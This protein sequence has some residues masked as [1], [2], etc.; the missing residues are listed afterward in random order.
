MDEIYWGKTLRAYLIAAGG[1]LVAL[2]VLRV[3]RTVV[4]TRLKKLADKTSFR[5]DD[6]IISTIQRFVVPF[7]YFMVAFQVVLSLNLDPRLRK[8]LNVLLTA[9]SIY[10]IVR[11]I[12]HVVHVLTNSFLKRRGESPS[13]IQQLNGLL[14]ILKGF[15]WILG[16]LFLLDNLGYNVTTIITTLG[17]GGI[18]IALAAQVILGD[19]FSYFAIFFDKPFEVGDFIAAGGH[20]GTIEHVGFKTTRIRSLSGEQ[21][22]MSNSE[23]LKNTIQ[24]YKRME[25][26]RVVFD[27]GVKYKTDRE[28]LNQ[29]PGM[30]KEIISRDST[31]VFD[32]AHLSNFT[33]QSIKFEVVYIKLTPDFNKHMDSQQTF[34]MNIYD[35]F[36]KRGIEFSHFPQKFLGQA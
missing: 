5:F 26:R 34:L 6:V 4:L 30:I 3:I 15:V 33:E 27:F 2:L 35:E 9:I 8:F 18:A 13:R 36:A 29:I 25:K 1:I 28:K 14:N 22:V 11:L 19:L 16:F 10:F 7:L 20:L 17:V 23:L 12:I 32:R 24:N 21:L 31:V